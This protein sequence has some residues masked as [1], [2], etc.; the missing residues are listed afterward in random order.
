M[1][2]VT[3][4]ADIIWA[5]YLPFDCQSILFVSSVYVTYLKEVPDNRAWRL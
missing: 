1:T 3:E 5:V 4:R 2:A